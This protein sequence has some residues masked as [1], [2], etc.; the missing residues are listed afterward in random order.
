M[1]WRDA[2]TTWPVQRAMLRRFLSIFRH[3][4]LRRGY[5]MWCGA[6]A[7]ASSR[8]AL[9]HRGLCHWMQSWHQACALASRLSASMQRGV[10]GFRHVALRRTLAMWAATAQRKSVARRLLM[11]RLSTWLM[12]AVHVWREHASSLADER[13]RRAQA[14]CRWQE[15][16]LVRVLSVLRAQGKRRSRDR[17]AGRAWVV[18]ALSSTLVRWRQCAAESN[19]ERGLASRWVHDALVRVFATWSKVLG[20]SVPF[21]RAMAFLLKRNVARSWGLWCSQTATTRASQQCLVR[22]LCRGKLA[23]LRRWRARHSLL[24]SLDGV[25]HT[26]QLQ[27]LCRFLRVWRTAARDQLGWQALTH[28]AERTYGSWPSHRRLLHVAVHHWRVAS[29]RCTVQKLASCGVR[30]L[31]GRGIRRWRRRALQNGFHVWRAASAALVLA[32][33][34]LRVLWDFTAMFAEEISA[35]QR[36]IHRWETETPCGSCSAS[37]PLRLSQH[38]SPH[39][40][41]SHSRPSP[42]NPFNSHSPSPCRRSPHSHSLRCHSLQPKP[43][44]P[45]A[46]DPDSWWVDG[47]VAASCI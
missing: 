10:S 29:Q 21:G 22:S 43:A 11:R 31:T 24:T 14:L 42:H 15:G 46:A 25:L 20:R 35:S 12:V 36:L 23:A 34:Q 17:A 44:S 45:E 26:A 30:M 8:H 19:A 7:M 39:D 41:S 18:L 33:K 6:R 40:C 16:A 27:T 3:R 37:S 38:H 28:M 2:F 1:T 32:A 47:T 5:V 9:L 13:Q 4:K